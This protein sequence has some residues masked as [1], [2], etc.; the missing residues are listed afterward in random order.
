MRLATIF[1]LLLLTISG[2]APSA[3]EDQDDSGKGSASLS[4]PPD[5][6]RLGK[7]DGGYIA[8]DAA[9]YADHHWSDGI[10]LC[11]EF[12]ARSLRAGSLP[13]KQFTWVPD[14]FAAVSE[15][16]YDEY[17]ANS[18][19]DVGGDVGDVVIYSND[20][21]DEFCD[22]E[23]TARYNCGHVGVITVAGTDKDSARADFHNR[24]HYRMQVGDILTGTRLGRGSADYSVY[25]VYHLS[26]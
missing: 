17:A 8:L 15:F 10:G 26:R 4:T 12:T 24:G 18:P 7:D 2:C 9:Y 20:V 1:P 11:A 14:L 3:I 25:R 19:T 16:P 23:N 13:I 21:G 22:R 5:P 6:I